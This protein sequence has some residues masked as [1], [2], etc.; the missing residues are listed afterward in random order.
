MIAW[1]TLTPALGRSLIDSVG[2]PV[3]ARGQLQAACH[4][5]A[6]D[7]AQDKNTHKALFLTRLA[8]SRKFLSR[9][10]RFCRK[11]NRALNDPKALTYRS[12]CD[13]G[14]RPS[15]IERQRILL[16]QREALKN[17]DHSKA[18]PGLSR[19]TAA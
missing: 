10:H 9:Y 4:D 5:S 7:E 3:V 14:Q 17:E 2:R 19:P 8:L 13:A 12:T 1:A 16:S 11:R 6:S 15:E 18:A